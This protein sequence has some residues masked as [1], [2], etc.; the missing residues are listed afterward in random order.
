MASEAARHE[1]RTRVIVTYGVLGAVIVALALY[2]VLRQ[3]GRVQYQL[4]VTPTVAA[5]EI[6]EIAV[7]MPDGVVIRLERSGEDWSISPQGY[8]ADESKIGDMTEAVAEFRIADLVA[9]RAFYERYDLDEDTKI[10]VVARG[11]GDTLLEF[12]A[13]KRAP[14]Y[15]HTYVLLPDDERVFHAT[16]DLRRVFDMTV[17]DL[18]NRL[19]LSFDKGIVEAL[20]VTLP[21]RNLRLVKSV[22]ET[23]TGEEAT[24][25]TV[26]REPTGETWAVDKIDDLLNRLDDLRCSEFLADEDADLGESQLEMVIG[27]DREYTL[28]LFSKTDDGYHAKSSEN[29]FPFLIS[30]WQGDSI[31]ETFEPESD[32]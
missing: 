10:S 22:Q 8:K 19:V 7:S 29:P 25:E 32:E 2:L 15:N 6:D 1:R 28:A 11:G 18:R 20:T 16:G 9:T 17:S 12:D 13:G 4:P 21:D 31:L 27:G 5:F 24:Q 26:W 3:Q 30:T 14:S 23:G